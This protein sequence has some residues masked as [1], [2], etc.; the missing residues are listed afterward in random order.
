MGFTECNSLNEITQAEDVK[1]YLG[2]FFPKMFLDIIPEAYCDLPLQEVKNKV[3]MPWGVPYI[4]EELLQA[5]N[6]A[7][8]IKRDKKYGIV[9]LWEEETDVYIPG[10]GTDNKSNVFLL[11]MNT[12][13][14]KKKPAVIIC[15]GGG[16]EMTSMNAEGVQIADKMQ[17][18][19]FVPFVLGYRTAPACYPAPQSDLILAMK[20]V[21]ANAGKYGVDTSDIMFMGFSAGGH[22]CASTAA[23][24]REL[25]PE[26]MQELQAYNPVLAE[27][28]RGISVRPD[29]LSLG[30]PVI[31]FLEEPHEGSVQALTGGN[32]NLREKLSVEQQVD[33]TYPETFIWVCED[34]ELVPPSNSRRMYNVLQKNGIKSELKEYP[35]GGHGCAL[36]KGTSAEGWFT[37]MLKFHGKEDMWEPEYFARKVAEDTWMIG[38]DLKDF[39][40]RTGKQIDFG[41]PSGN[42][43]LIIGEKESVLIDSAA[44][45]PGL[46]R[47]VEQLTGNPVRLVLSHAHP[48]HRYRLKEFEEFWIHPKDEDLLHGAYNWG[49]YEEIPEIVH[50]L[51]H[52]DIWDIGKGHRLEIFH[53][54]GHTDGSIL[55]LD[56]KTG[57][58]FTGD[59]IGRR[60]L[61]GTCGWVPVEDY[62]RSLEEIKTL[63][64]DGICSCHDRKILDK[65]LIDF[66]I[67]GI[68]KFPK[69]DKVVQYPGS[70]PLH[71]LIRGDYNGMFFLDFSYP[72]SVLNKQ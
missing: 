44:D 47:F 62:I 31:S 36:A 1:Q 46:R 59:A 60:L 38:C 56:K 12:Y 70:E 4:V 67:E 24:Y 29:A 37:A 69:T 2:I 9:P 21:K 3:T 57:L 34:D 45:L 32:E 13:T 20:Y 58:L 51:N 23:L 28:Y 64:F 25:E 66:I 18:A 6:I 10:N 33:E 55:I 17:E 41:M 52:G 7:G 15:P 53:M 16:Y 72:E 54:P 22:L 43:W 71:N 65:E 27:K 48:D 5:A 42:S 61:Y 14:E 8:E 40:N 11:H 35:S 49:G 50:Y 19:G 30:Y 39:G 68:S 63:A 26:V